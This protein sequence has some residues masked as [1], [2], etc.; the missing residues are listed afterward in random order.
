MLD[1]TPPDF[2]R[3]GTLM[4]IDKPTSYVTDD[5]Y[6]NE[7]EKANAGAARDVNE[8]TARLRDIN[9]SPIIRTREIDS[10]F[11]LGQFLNSEGRSSDQKTF[12]SRLDTNEKQEIL[13]NT[14]F[15]LEDSIKDSTKEDGKFLAQ[16]I[17]RANS[18]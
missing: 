12:N 7:I 14:P 15:D 18:N 2:L 5:Q 10:K 3:K 6:Y 9:E 8:L 1:I 13:K 16:P 11:Q 4:R 17:W